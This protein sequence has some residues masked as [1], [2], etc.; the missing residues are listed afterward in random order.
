MKWDRDMEQAEVTAWARL[1]K[2]ETDRNL[3][4]GCFLR[5]QSSF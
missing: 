2:D 1:G 3:G 4:T 5:T